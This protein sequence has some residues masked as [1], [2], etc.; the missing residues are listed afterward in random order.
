MPRIPER[1]DTDLRS[2]PKCNLH[3]HLEGS[4][5]PETFWELAREQGL[6]PGI[7]RERV[8]RLLQVDGREDSLV[9]YLEKISL[10]YQVMKTATA[11]RRTAFEAAEDAAR[12][13][14]VYFEL[15]AGP[16]THVHQGLT[17][18]QAI[19]AMLAGLHEAETHYPVTCRLIVAALRHHDPAANVDLARAA[20][21]HKDEGVVGFDLAGDEAGYPAGPHADA[22][23]VARDG[24]LGI[25]VHAGEA[26][27]PDN[28]RYAVEVLGAS[29]IGHGVRS[30]E[31]PEVMDGLLERG[32]TLEVCPLS[33]VHTRAVEGL[34]SHPVRRIF[35][36]G[37]RLSI[38]D[39]DP[40][41]SDT[42]VS[43]ELTL[44]RHGFGFDDPEIAAI[45]RM[46]LEAAFGLDDGQRAALIGAV[47][48]GAAQ[49][50][51]PASAG[52][53]A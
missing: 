49:L 2:L 9:G 18:H 28:V 14:V 6:D 17:V 39:D 37:I 30:V 51:D 23:R 19:E 29:R 43:K 24:G 26:A 35:D 11:L 20:V 3:S 50:G 7:P 10:G 52:R 36:A 42:S 16:L 47:E 5:R 31:S 8:A 27:G 22:F 46:G 38:G 12:D 44:L 33:N 53:V 25:T 21:E 34:A 4:L 1:A 45:Q 32:I 15:R 48:A 13:G 41:T 40:V